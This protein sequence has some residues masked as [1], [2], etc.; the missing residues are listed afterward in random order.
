MKIEMEKKYISNGE[1]IRVL[2]V[3]R[4]HIFPVLALYEDGTI[5]YCKEDGSCFNGEKYD[6]V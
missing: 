5:L 2:C 3:D 1:P 4:K 6:L